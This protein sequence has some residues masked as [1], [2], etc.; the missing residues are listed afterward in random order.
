MEKVK[1]SSNCANA[2]NIL[3]HMPFLTCVNGRRKI[4]PE[5]QLAPLYGKQMRNNCTHSNRVDPNR[6]GNVRLPC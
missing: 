3:P 2:T 4:C 5:K 6:S 1:P